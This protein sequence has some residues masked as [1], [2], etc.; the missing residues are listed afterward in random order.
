MP[1]QPTTEELMRE[2]SLGGEHTEVSMFG[3][4]TS[5]WELLPEDPQEDDQVVVHAPEDEIDQWC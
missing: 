1:E 2:Y 3:C 5:R 4:P